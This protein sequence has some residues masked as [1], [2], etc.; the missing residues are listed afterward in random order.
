VSTQDRIAAEAFGWMGPLTVMVGTLLPSVNVGVFSGQALIRSADGVVI[1]ALA[2]VVI[3]A[4]L[5]RL[6]RPG[7]SG[8]D[9]ASGTGRQ[10]SALV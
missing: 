3:L 8:L 9:P 10:W 6:H 2:P 5:P 4:R 7:A 1:A